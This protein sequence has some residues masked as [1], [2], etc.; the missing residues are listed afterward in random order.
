MRAALLSVA[1]VSMCVPDAASAAPQQD[2]NPP[3]LNPNLS[4]LAE[5]N[6][7]LLFNR[8][9]AAFDQRYAAHLAKNPH[10]NLA[11]G[12]AVY[13]L[14]QELQALID[15]WRATGKLTYLEDARRL[16]L[17]AI[18][19]AKSNQRPLLWR[20]QQRGN[21]PCF[22]SKEI[23]KA[24]GGHGQLYDFQ[25]SAGFLM[26]A[27][28]LKQADR[29]D[30]K[31]IADFVELNIVEKWLS[32]NPNIRPEQLNPSELPDQSNMYL[33]VVLNTSRDTREHFATICMNLHRLGYTKYP[34]K[35]W[36][37]F[38][39]E[40][41][42]GI[43]PNM[44]TTAPRAAALGGHAPADWGVVPNKSTGG[45]V[46]H[47]TPNWR[48]PN[49][50]AVLDTS[51]ANRTVWLAAQAYYEGLIEKGRLGNFIS[52]LKLQVWAPAKGPFYFNNLIDGSDSEVQKMPPGRKG[53]L[54]F[55]WHRLAAYDKTLE[56]LFISIAY[57]LTNGGPNIPEGA[58]NKAM[59]EAPL[60]L[61]AWAAR[62]I[63]PNGQPQLFP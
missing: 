54:W 24:T 41:Y 1:L 47:F 33:L 3:A 9:V 45:Y 40:L 10:K 50:V 13:Y 7:P 39:T 26:V 51:H 59:E 15:M 11:E 35:Q 38:L 20:N 29:N 21:W 28:A 6:R 42:I 18:S 61:F 53:N 34:Y 37:I 55:G 63:S 27:N 8:L 56:R 58:Q 36:A 43:R 14:R 25:G 52:T 31:E 57:D 30:W 4:P 23:E 12:Y 46:W 22:Y 44:D 62:L 32:Y 2:T 19:D 17:K 60:C 5:G 16:V 48:L 49:Q